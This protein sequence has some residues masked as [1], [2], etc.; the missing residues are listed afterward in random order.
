MKIEANINKKYFIILLGA[1]LILAGVIYGYAYGGNVPDV[2]GHSGNEIH[3]D[4]N[5]ETKL[6]NEALAGLSGGSSWEEVDLDSTEL[7]DTDCMY[8]WT[9]DDGYIADTPTAFVSLFVRDNKLWWREGQDFTPTTI[10]AS[11]KRQ[12]VG[13]YSGTT[14]AIYKSCP[15][16]GGTGGE[17]GG[18]CDEGMKDGWPDAISCIRTDNSGWMH[19]IMSYEVGDLIYYRTPAGA[20]SAD[21]VF[22]ENAESFNSGTTPSDCA[23]KTIDELENMGRTNYFSCGGGGSGLSQDNCAWTEWFRQEEC[24]DGCASSPQYVP[25]GSYIAGIDYDAVTGGADGKIRFYYCEGSSGSLDADYDSG[26][27]NL[28]GGYNSLTLNHNLGTSFFKN[29]MIYGSC[30]SD[31]S[32]PILVE[33]VSSSGSGAYGYSLNFLTENSVT[34]ES[35]QHGGM[36]TSECPGSGT[37]PQGST[38]FRLMIWE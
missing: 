33:G 30:G 26:W 21:L 3:V 19:Y 9:T 14:K 10:S 36:L 18:V 16:A 12:I 6:L 20:N 22:N 28:A 23:G 25:E 32:K 15:G 11:N 29:V 27:V 35:Y 37:P 24:S 7:F 13:Q 5:G 8:Y 38:H 31:T 2:M 17:F 4:F 1:I 34:V